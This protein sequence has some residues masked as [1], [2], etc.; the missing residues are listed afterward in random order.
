MLIEEFIIYKYDNVFYTKEELEEM[1]F[2]YMCGR[3]DFKCLKENSIDYEILEKSKLCESFHSIYDYLNFDEERLTGKFLYDF[4]NHG[5][6][7][8]VDKYYGIRYKKSKTSEIVQI[9]S[10]KSECNRAYIQ[11]EVEI[12]KMFEKFHQH[13]RDEYNNASKELLNQKKQKETREKVLNLIN[14][15]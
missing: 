8:D 12:E 2:V 15:K 5:L 7:L 1:G 3:E 14:K 6:I 10:E 11:L 13:T 9:F 4:G